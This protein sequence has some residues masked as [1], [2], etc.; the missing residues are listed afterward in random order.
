M[1]TRGRFDPV[2]LSAFQGDLFC[3]HRAAPPDH[4]RWESPHAWDPH[5]TRAPSGEGNYGQP[6]V[7]SCGCWP[8][9]QVAPDFPFAAN[10][11]PRTRKHAPRAPRMLPV[12]SYPS[13]RL[14][15]RV[16]GPELEVFTCPDTGSRCILGS[17]QILSSFPHSAAPPRSP[18]MVPP[19]RT[20]IDVWRTM[21]LCI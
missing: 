21:R 7:D 8:E 18:P 4:P 13:P 6:R 9:R 12:T 16:R 3:I 5:I 15:R 19:T 14:V 10:P 17:W 20:A 1:T 11:H 2:C